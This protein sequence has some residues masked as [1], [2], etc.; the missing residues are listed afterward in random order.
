M[1]L[2]ILIGSKEGLVH[3]KTVLVRRRNKIFFNLQNDG[4]KI[5]CIDSRESITLSEI[6]LHKKRKFEY[7]TK[8]A[9]YGTPRR[10]LV[11]N[12]T[13]NTTL[14]TPSKLNTTQ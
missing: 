2:V 8:T 14:N 1:T 10:P 12:T 5:T 13:L 11:W 9:K 4:S 6:R 3:S 7:E